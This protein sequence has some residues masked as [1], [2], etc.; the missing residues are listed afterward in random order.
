MLSH[1]SVPSPPLVFLILLRIH[2]VT[3]GK[4]SGALTLLHST[5]TELLL[6]HV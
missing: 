5:G 3:H 4:V 2:L 1:A 6:Q